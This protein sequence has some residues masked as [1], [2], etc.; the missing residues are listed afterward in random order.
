MLSLRYRFDSTRANLVW[1]TGI[2]IIEKLAGYLV[3]AV[4]TRTLT[5]VEIGEIFFASTISGI[6]ATVLSFGTEHHLIRAVATQPDRAVRNL[7]EVLALRLQNMVLVY[8]AVNL[9]CWALQPS[10]APVLMLVTAYDFLEEIYYAF[11]SFFAGTKQLIYRLVIGGIVE[12]LKLLAVSAVAVL[13]RSIYAVLA[14]YLIIDTGLVVGTYL[15][16]RRDFGEI[17]LAF[18]WKQSLSLMRISMP[19]FVFNILT[20][21][22]MRLDTLMVGIMLNLVQVAYY[23][24]GMKMLEV[25]RFVIRPLNSVF[26]PI[27]SEMAAAGRW[28]A[29]RKRSLQLTGAAFGLGLLGTLGMQ[30]L[31]S[32]V[33]VLLFGADYTASVA[34]AKILFL[35][36]PLIFVHFVLTILANALHLEKASAWLL[37]VSALLNFVLNL[38]V[39]PRY[40]IDGAAWTTLASQTVLTASVMWL[41]A[42]KLLRPKPA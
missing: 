8:A 14:T 37:A 27:F 20:L 7:G 5:T 42:S 36:L 26:Y 6:A 10:L 38:Y 40:G 3:I 1:A 16:V 35:S 33:I 13:T 15:V 2:Q 23:D 28:E 34:P 21:V 32:P 25:A 22:H 11:S 29:L 24:L 30:V 12:F 41:T 17:P 39:I 31:G 4:L 9:G 19:F 18:G